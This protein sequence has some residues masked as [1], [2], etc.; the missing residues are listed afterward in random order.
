MQVKNKIFFECFT[1]NNC[2]YI[3][4]TFYGIQSLPWRLHRSV[5][6]KNL[7]QWQ[8]NPIHKYIATLP[9]HL[10]FG[11]GR[12]RQKIMIGSFLY[13]LDSQICLKFDVVNPLFTSQ[14]ASMW[15]G[16][17]GSVVPTGTKKKGKKSQICY[18][19]VFW[20][21]KVSLNQDCALLEF[22]DCNTAATVYD[23]VIQWVWKNRWNNQTATGQDLLQMHQCGLANVA[24]WWAIPLE[25][26][27]KTKKSQIC[28]F[29]VFATRDLTT[30]EANLAW[31]DS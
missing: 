8:F 22:A 14:N 26:K 20:R 13:P 9:I 19:F 10:T 29:F 12:E 1:I 28:Y 15:T 23:V 16:W 6:R 25:P 4:V 27:K 3:F 30:V 24:H 2:E 21:P 5:F 18:F 11:R 31:M 7:V 17:C